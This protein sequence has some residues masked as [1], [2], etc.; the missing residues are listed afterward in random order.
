MVTDLFR[1]HLPIP[2]WYTLTI[3]AQDPT[4]HKR[5]PTDDKHTIL[6]AAVQVPS[7]WL[8]PGPRSHRFHVVDYDEAASGL[9]RPAALLQPDSRFS[10]NPEEWR[11]RDDFASADDATL[12]SDSSFHA[13]NVFAVAAR[14]L[15][16]FETSL[17][18][19]VPWSFEAHQ[20]FLV[21]HAMPT[22][23]AFYSAEDEAIFFGYFFNGGQRIDTCLSHD[24]IVHEATHAVLDGL[25]PRLTEPGQQDQ[26]AF[27]EGFADI[28]ALLSVF[29]MPEVVAECLPP[30][31]RNGRIPAEAVTQEQLMKTALFTLAEQW[32]DAEAGRSGLR[33]SVLLKPGV[34][35]KEDSDFDPPHR[36]GEIIVAAVMQSLVKIWTDRIESP[37]LQTVNAQNAIREGAKSASH[38][39][40]MVIRSLDYAPPVGLEFN[41]FL[42]AII[43][44]D[45]VMVPDDD[46]NYRK[47]LIDSFGAFGVRQPRGQ[48]IDLADRPLLY[49]NLS[50]NSMRVDRDE[51]YRFIWQNADMLEIKR[52]YQTRVDQVLPSIRVGPDGFV[53]AETVVRYFQELEC[54]AAE[55]LDLAAQERAKFGLPN[56]I[57]AAQPI[58]ICG[59][60]ALIFDQF[61]RVKY[62]QHKRI[63]DFDRQQKRLD[64]LVRTLPPDTEQRYGFLPASR[65]GQSSRPF[66]GPAE[67]IQG[68]W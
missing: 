16:A 21:P 48:I 57:D 61:G 64:Y 34:S 63:L 60:G 65:L 4:I 14:T 10:G 33:G 55:L 51:A 2:R 28:V 56:G 53:V 36:R 62:H 3:I 45:E 29:S 1:E 68:E 30:P 52:Q 11:I 40:N 38:L 59:G 17:G 23:N 37:I 9:I 32:G 39:L 8:E 44:A 12:L 43:V 19:R 42:D 50:F 15:S 31:D 26:A 27:H 22:E 24:V 7:D 5:R 46:H 49:E 47:T 41:D 20:L 67:S 13:Q 58:R 25:L 18:R 6:T 54:T 35:W 66:H